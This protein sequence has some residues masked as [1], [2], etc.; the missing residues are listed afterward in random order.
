[1]RDVT[2]DKD[3]SQVRTVNGPRVV[4]SLRNLALSAIRM[5]GHE[6]IAAAIR[7]YPAR[8]DRTVTRLLNS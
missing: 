6:N 2:Y 4:A 7:H 1:M 3:R 5:A 8:S